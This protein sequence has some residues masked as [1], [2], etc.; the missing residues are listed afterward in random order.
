MSSVKELLMYG[1]ENIKCGDPV[2]GVKLGEAQIMQA[3][4]MMTHNDVTE[5]DDVDSVIEKYPDCGIQ[6]FLKL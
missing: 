3:F 5:N 1:I 2:F 6:N 4:Q